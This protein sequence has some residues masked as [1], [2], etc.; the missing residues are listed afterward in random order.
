MQ[1]QNW[2]KWPAS[3]VLLALFI[4]P[5]LLPAA[6]PEA[7]KPISPS[8]T[9]PAKPAK[10][11]K[12][13]FEPPTDYIP[14]IANLQRIQPSPRLLEKPP[15]LESSFL[16]GEFLIASEAPALE[17][18]ILPDQ[19]PGGKLW[20]YWGDALYASNGK[21]YISTGD[22]DTPRGHT[23]LYEVDPKTGE[24]RIVVDV[25]VLVGIDKPIDQYSPGKIHAP[26]I[27]GGDGW[28]YF[29]T[30]RGKVEHTTAELRYQGDW[31]IR[32]NLATGKAENLGIPV[33]HNSVGAMVF[34][35]P[36]K[37]LYGLG[38]YGM[39]MAQ[40]RDLFFAYN[41]EKRELI[42]HGGPEIHGGRAIVLADDG[43]AY[44]ESN[45]FMVRYD[46]KTNTAVQLDVKVPGNGRLRAASFPND[47]GIAYCFSRDGELFAFDTTTEK[48][49]LITSSFV[50]GPQYT[51]VCKLDPTGRY[52]YYIPSAHGD[53][54]EH[55]TAVVQFD[56]KTR[57]RK[58]LAFLNEF[59][60]QEKGYNLGGS[61][62]LA[63]N[64]DGSDLL[65]C[66]NG[67]PWR[68]DMDAEQM[69]DADFGQCSV[70]ILHIPQ[71]E[72]S[73]KN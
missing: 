41:I 19:F 45:G 12:T 32:Y 8:K 73:A 51:A 26:I 22:H 34:H 29:I 36:S 3:I 38:A 31:L 58:V 61:L 68:E 4:S 60:R 67:G 10:P 15:A 1:I 17:W 13:R 14:T 2:M 24:M 69:K 30:Y 7:D 40:R 20:S 70:M 56:T 47:S 44:Y 57:Q 72:R 49:E 28:I 52:L 59:F 33:P 39:T 6:E 48:V 43:R 55:G 5:N 71:S 11:P 64:R 27:E 21:Y 35:E 16:K 23:Y 65:I 50:A 53:S 54:H 9:K 18:A 66:W 62:S 42:F 25:N 37:I 46:P 63:L